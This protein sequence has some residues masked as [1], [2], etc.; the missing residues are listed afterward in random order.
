MRLNLIHTFDGDLAISLISPT[1]TQV[2]LS[3]RV[4]GGGDNFTNTVFDDEAG[5]SISAGTAPFTGSFR[6]S[7][8]L[9]AVDGQAMSGNWR[10]RIEDLAGI[11]EGSLTSWSVV[12]TTACP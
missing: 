8:P 6:P 1:G 5:T 2:S 4:G 3:N 7:T 12:I 11:D 10:L 9:N